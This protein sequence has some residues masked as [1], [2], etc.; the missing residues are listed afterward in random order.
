MFLVGAFLKK[1]ARLLQSLVFF[2]QD[3]VEATNVNVQYLQ[4]NEYPGNAS[5]LF[6]RVPPLVF[7]F[8]LVGAF[9]LKEKSPTLTVSSFFFSVD[10]LTLSGPL[11]LQ[12]LFIFHI[13]SSSIFDPAGERGF[14]SR[15]KP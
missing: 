1:K 11:F 15:T 8:L 4:L 3:R 2:I 5:K 7:Y 13:C 14:D 9:S 6:Q 10:N 12:F